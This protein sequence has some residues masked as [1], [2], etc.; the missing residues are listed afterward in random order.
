MNAIDVKKVSK[1]KFLGTSLN[2]ECDSSSE[3][4]QRIEVARVF[5]FKLF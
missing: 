1:Y 5:L 3:I 4:K 2:D